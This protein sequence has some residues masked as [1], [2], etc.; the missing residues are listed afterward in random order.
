MVG[1]LHLPELRSDEVSCREVSTA[2]LVEHRKPISQKAFNMT[3]SQ[4]V[5]LPE[6]LGDKIAEAPESSYG[7]A[8]VTVVLKD[9]RRFSDVEVGGDLKV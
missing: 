3:G 2:E 9:G 7:V 5:Y 1:L 6:F 8:K 4:P